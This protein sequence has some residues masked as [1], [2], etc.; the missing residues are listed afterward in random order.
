MPEQLALAIDTEECL[1]A[2]GQEVDLL[3]S[4]INACGS[5]PR[6]AV[7]DLLAD[8]D[9]LRDQLYIASCLLSK[10]IARGWKPQYERLP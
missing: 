7:R 3:E 6:A 4:I 1:P 8:A 5:D 2:A 9:F 10:G